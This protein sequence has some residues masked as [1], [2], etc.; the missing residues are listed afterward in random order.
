MYTGLVGL[1]TIKA[2]EKIEAKNF[3]RILPSQ[4]FNSELVI[5]KNESFVLWDISG[6]LYHRQFWPN[7]L[8]S[9]PASVILYVVNANEPTERLNESKMYLH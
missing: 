2:F 1:E 7:Y 5:R 4:G 3:T 8:K 9:I 6:D